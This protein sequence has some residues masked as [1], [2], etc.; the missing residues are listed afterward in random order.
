MVVL[1][2][3]CTA[4]LETVIDDKVSVFVGNVI[5]LLTVFPLSIG[6][7]C[8]LFNYFRLFDSKYLALLGKHSYEFFLVHI[9]VLS[10]LSD[11]TIK[12]LVIFLL[13]TTGGSFFIS[14]V[15]NSLI[16]YIKTSVLTR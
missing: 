10:F 13:L 8:F 2:F 4:L 6:V 11:R 15:S 3:A 12:G 1:G 9:S 14:L 5:S 7:V 16:S